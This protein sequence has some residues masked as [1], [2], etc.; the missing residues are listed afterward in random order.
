MKVITFNVNGIRSMLTKDKSGKKHD[1]PIVNNVIREL[2][3]EQSPDLLCMQE[4]KCTS[5]DIDIAVALGLKE[6]GYVSCEVNCA[7]KRGYSG[8][9]I[10]SKKAPL[11]VLRGFMGF[12][13]NVELNDEG[14]VLTFE[15]DNVIVVNVY[16]P[17]SKP[18]L[19]RL[20][21]RVMTWDR[22]MAEYIQ[23]LQ[24]TTKKPV[25]LCGDMN[26]APADIDVNNPKSAKGSHGFT[27][28]EKQSFEALLDETEMVDAYRVVHPTKVAYT[29]FSPFSKSKDADGYRDKGWRIDH[30][31]VS[32]KAKN[33]IKKVDVLPQYWGS[34]H[35][36]CSLDIDINIKTT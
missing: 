22:T 34:D 18:D 21:W 9:C 28:S 23:H 10:I 32:C 1:K 6:L 12:N 3:K 13:D 7:V 19:S 29:W 33:K 4:I 15:Y 14:R 30:F 17:N 5:S 36:A 27:E 16:T 25:I 35:V 11:K 8:T 20:E 24:E 2:L 26:V 31:L